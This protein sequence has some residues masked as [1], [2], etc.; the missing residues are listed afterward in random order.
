MTATLTTDVPSGL[1][2]YRL[3]PSPLA[4]NQIYTIHHTPGAEIP[5]AEYPRPLVRVLSVDNI[6][7]YKRFHNLTML[8]KATSPDGEPVDV[9]QISGRAAIF[10]GGPSLKRNVSFTIQ[11]SANMM[12]MM[13]MLLEPM[14]NQNMIPDPNMNANI[15]IRKRPTATQALP[16]TSPFL[17]KQAMELA[18]LKKDSCPITMDDFTESN[19]AVMPCGH[20]FTTLA[21]AESFKKCPNQCPICRNPGLATFV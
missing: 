13:N 10:K 19:T 4:L 3:T 9:Y 2:A 8:F 18:I 7:L 6:L 16:T 11:H 17:A 20:L 15:T 1:N 12:N 14:P 5:V 21:I